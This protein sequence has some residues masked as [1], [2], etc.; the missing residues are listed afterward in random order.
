MRTSVS[1]EKIV[2]D[3]MYLLFL[4]NCVNRKGRLKHFR[5]PLTLNQQPFCLK[6]SIFKSSCVVETA[7]AEQGI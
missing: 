2:R 3:L 5:R 7:V 4:I 1:P 6:R